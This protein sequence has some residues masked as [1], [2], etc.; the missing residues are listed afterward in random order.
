MHL[1]MF[2][3]MEELEEAQGARQRRS[4]LFPPSPHLPLEIFSSPAVPFAPSLPLP[5]S[6]HPPF[7]P[8]APSTPP[9]P[10]LP[11]LIAS[12]DQGPEQ[13]APRREFKRENTTPA[14][15]P[16]GGA[17]AATPPKRQFKRQPPVA[18][19]AA[20]SGPPKRE[21]KRKLQP[22]DL[23]PGAGRRQAAAKPAAAVPSGPPVTQDERAKFQ[24]EKDAFYCTLPTFPAL[25]LPL[26]S[27]SPPDP[28][29]SA[30]H[31]P[32]LN[33]HRPFS[34]C[35]LP[36]FSCP[37]HLSPAPLTAQRR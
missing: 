20:A 24:E 37:P 23:A 29:S 2:K 1:A 18:G 19:G 32:L 12:D 26:S 13:V 25:F 11:L 35:P 28:P 22:G 6:T 36:P 15:P 33:R 27:S 7:P 21:F 31:C 30:R 14:R 17:P 34:V 8:S 5:P 9:R 10:P 4:P 3:Q 16:A